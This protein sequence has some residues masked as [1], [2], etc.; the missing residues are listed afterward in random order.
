MGWTKHVYNYS[1]LTLIPLS[2]CIFNYS[3]II[4]TIS[5]HLNTLNKFLSSSPHVNRKYASYCYPNKSINRTINKHTNKH[6]EVV[7]SRSLQFQC[8]IVFVMIVIVIVFLILYIYITFI[9]FIY[10]NITLRKRFQFPFWY[11][12]YIHIQTQGPL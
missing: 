6:A 10:E 2:H 11:P 1:K 5:I 3:L 7:D 4:H 12:F 9:F 8:L